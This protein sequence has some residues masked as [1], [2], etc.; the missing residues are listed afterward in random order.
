MVALDTMKLH[1]AKKFTTYRND[2]V[3][4]KAEEDDRN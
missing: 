2:G 1:P 4:A 3:L